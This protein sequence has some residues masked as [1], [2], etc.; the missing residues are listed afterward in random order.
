MAKLKDSKKLKKF[1]YKLKSMT[2]VDLQIMIG[3]MLAIPLVSKNE[4]LK[5][6]LTVALVAITAYIITKTILATI[7]K[8]IPK[9]K[10]AKLA[11]DAAVGGPMGTP[12]P[13][14]ATD[15][16]TEVTK[17]TSKNL[18]DKGK[19]K[20]KDLP[21]TVFGIIGETEIPVTP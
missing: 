7:Q 14:A 11:F 3:I 9:L 18:V 17:D 2:I 12:N 1:K 15:L 6:V 21:S 20:V 5:R 19:N 4:R 8:L 13:P 10:K 16:A